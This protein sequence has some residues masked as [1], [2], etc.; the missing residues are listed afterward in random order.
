MPESKKVGLVLS[1]GAYAGWMQLGA[2][3]VLEEEG[4]SF[5]IITGVSVGGLIGL[6]LAN[7]IPVKDIIKRAQSLKESDFKKI[8]ISHGAM[9]DPSYAI[10]KL[11]KFLGG[12]KNF[13]DLPKKFAVVAVDV[14]TGDEVVL[15]KG[16]VLKAVQAT[17]SIPGI[18]PP[19]ELDGKFLV[20]GGLLNPLPVD[21]A[22]SMGASTTIAIE[23]SSALQI[24]FRGRSMNRF[25]KRL[26]ESTRNMYFYMWFKKDYLVNSVW[27]A[28]RLIGNKIKKEKLK[29][30]PPTFLLELSDPTK[31]SDIL[32]SDS[33][34]QRA[35]LIKVGRQAATS[36]LD[37]IKKAL[38]N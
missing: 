25:Q 7:E 23:A 38:E 20:D 37:K 10:S 1:G 29:N 8:T 30:Y 22:L 9:F 36:S 18:F 2:L 5:D 14:I 26:V 27:D 12:E 35:K 34:K 6:G 11:K 3:Q 13:E 16:P 24:D 15:D 28:F 33:K 32:Q 19:V 31:R 4:I 21:V 17:M